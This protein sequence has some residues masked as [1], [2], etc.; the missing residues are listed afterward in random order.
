LGVHLPHPMNTF[1]CPTYG[2]PVVKHRMLTSAVESLR[3]SWVRN[4]FKLRT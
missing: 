2:V 4:L 1:A 3:L